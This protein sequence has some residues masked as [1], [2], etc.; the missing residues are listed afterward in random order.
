MKLTSPRL[1]AIVRARSISMIVR[2]SYGLKSLFGFIG[3]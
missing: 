1:F 2:G 3:G